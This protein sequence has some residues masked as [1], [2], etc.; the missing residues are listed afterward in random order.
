MERA[1]RENCRTGPIATTTRSAVSGLVAALAAA[2][3][4][5]A[6]VVLHLYISS[7]NSLVAGAV[8]LPLL[9]AVTQ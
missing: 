6:V 4:S 5:K 8:V 2:A 9:L 7:R 3:G 1:R